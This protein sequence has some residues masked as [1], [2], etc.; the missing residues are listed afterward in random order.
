ML[1]I[2]F[3]LILQ[4]IGS[5]IPARINNLKI[6]V[7]SGNASLSAVNEYFRWELYFWEGVHQVFLDETGFTD[8]VIPSY[9]N[10]KTFDLT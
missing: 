3:S 10:F 9:D 2:G 1:V 6:Y 4:I 7:G 8:S 5:V